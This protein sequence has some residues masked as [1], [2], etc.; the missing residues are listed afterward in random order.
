MTFFL[1]HLQPLCLATVQNKIKVRP[2]IKI[3]YCNENWTSIKFLQ[4]DQQAGREY[5]GSILQY[6]CIQSLIDMILKS[7]NAAL[8]GL[9]Q[10]TKQMKHNPSS[11]L[12]TQKPSNIF[13]R[14][15][16]NKNRLVA[17]Y[18]QTVNETSNSVVFAPPAN[19]TISHPLFSHPLIL[20]CH[21][22]PTQPT[23]LTKETQS[24][25]IFD[26]IVHVHTVAYRW[27]FGGFWW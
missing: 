1:L 19:I 23:N 5:I 22:Q 16:N 8:S 7:S 18:L 25:L 2:K 13:H 21:D 26:D 11:Y 4:N 10:P 27:C 17:A 9:N 12:M 15:V 14:I 6:Y 20:Y 3:L 24:L